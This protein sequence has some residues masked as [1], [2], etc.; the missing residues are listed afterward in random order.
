LRKRRFRVDACAAPRLFA[1]PKASVDAVQHQLRV[2]DFVLEELD[3]SVPRR[4]VHDHELVPRLRVLE[5]CLERRPQLAAESVAR[6]EDDRRFGVASNGGKD[7]RSH[8]TAARRSA[9]SSA[10]SRSTSLAS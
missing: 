1:A 3:G 4:V 2:L 5:Q 10:R 6:E 9:S 8:G 7:Q